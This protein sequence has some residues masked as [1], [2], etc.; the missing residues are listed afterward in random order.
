MRDLAVVA[1][2]E[3]L[4]HDLPVRLDLGLPAGV[5]DER[6]DVE[7]ELRDL[8]GQRAERLRERLGVGVGVRED[9]RAPGVDRDG[10]EAELVL[11][12]V[13]LLLAARRRAE[14]AVEPVRPGV[15]RALQRL[16]ARLPLGE[17][18]A[19]VAADVDEAAQD[20]VSVARDDDRC[21]AGLAWRSSRASRAVRC[22]RRTATR[23]GGSAPPPAAGSRD[24]CTRRTA[25]SDPPRERT[26]LSRPR[27]VAATGH[28]PVSD[29]K[30]GPREPVALDRA[31]SPAGQGQGG[32]CSV[33]DT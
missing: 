24:P 27:P 26:R 1:L 32:H 7:P 2:E 9:E 13:R 31:G 12:E 28:V 10:N 6:V 18:G 17:G 25:A 16:A 8:R 29:T 23:G 19:A 15:V 21:A 3:V 22:G 14:A 20:A 33:S 5:V 30:T 11:R 4:A